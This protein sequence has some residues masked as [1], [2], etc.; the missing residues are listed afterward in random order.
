MNF[1][2]HVS[3]AGGIYK[4]PGRAREVGADVFQ[5]FSRSPRGGPFRASDDDIKEFKAQ[6]KE[7]GFERWYVHTPYY[8]TLATDN[9]K[10]FNGSVESLADEL[11]VADKMGT[12][13]IVTHQG[14][15]KERT[16]EEGVDQVI[17][18]LN[19]IKKKYPL[20][21]LLLEVAAGT[22]NVVGDSL[23]DLARIA[24][25]VPELG[26]IG[27]DTCHLFA[28]GYDLR[29]ERHV[30]D[31]ETEIERT[32]GMERVKFIHLND[33]KHEFA[34]NKDRHELLG[35]GHIGDT[36]LSAFVQS[37]NFASID[38]VLETPYSTDD[39]MRSEL[40]KA[41]ALASKK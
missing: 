31:L 30:Q 39:E 17:V 16:K 19:K 12:T 24:D 37:K 11:E 15:A 20:D 21:K 32:I 5:F 13:Y 40:K 18:G 38:M 6:C 33:S 7:H 22:G 10:N 3:I 35:Q 4:A 26:G 34:A 25:A 14:S 28:A 36:G 1:G 29:T 27:L 41:R 8:I 23:E 9:P 2:V